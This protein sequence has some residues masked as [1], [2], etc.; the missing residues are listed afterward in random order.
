MKVEFGLIVD[1]KTKILVAVNYTLDL[2]EWA[3]AAHGMYES[4]RV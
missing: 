4:L 3:I 2:V 1:G